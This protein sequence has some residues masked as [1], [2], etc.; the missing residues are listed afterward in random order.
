MQPFADVLPLALCKVINRGCF[1]VDEEN[2][3]IQK[4]FILTFTKALQ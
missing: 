4:S 3:D 1:S 2:R